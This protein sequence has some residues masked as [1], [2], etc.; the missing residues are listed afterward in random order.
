MYDDQKLRQADEKAIRFTHRL[1]SAYDVNLNTR[2]ASVETGK[3]G[4][5]EDFD[6]HVPWSTLP[7]GCC[8]EPMD[9]SYHVIVVKWDDGTKTD[10]SPEDLLLAEN[11]PK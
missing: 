9:E 4:T 6:N 5:V 3:L 10:E 7:C 1:L 11:L 8:S 2:V